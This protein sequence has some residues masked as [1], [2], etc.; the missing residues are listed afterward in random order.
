MNKKNNRILLIVLVA[1]LALYFGK[2]YLGNS[3]DRNFKS[4]LVAVDTAAVN[5]IV[6]N[7]KSNQNVPITLTRTGSEWE[8][9][10]GTIEDNASPSIMSGILSSLVSMKPERLIAK[11][12]DKW[13]T[14]QV[15]DSL[16]TDVKVYSDD[17]LLADLVVG[18]FNY[19]QATRSMS[20]S[21]RL[22]NS[23][24]VY[25]VKGYLSSTFN[26][27]TNDFRDK[28]FV[29]VKTEDLTKIAFTYPGDSSYV[30]EKSANGWQIDGQRADSV[31]VRNYLAGLRMM[32]MREFDDGFEPASHEHPYQ[33]MIDGDNINTITVT[34]YATE[35]GLVLH[36]SM[37]EDAY[38]KQ[39]SFKPFDKLFVHKQKFI[40]N[41]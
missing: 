13:D 17:K 18:K 36:S 30:L 1:L 20:T 26:R 16:G 5:K 29:K 7:A 38:F 37:N 4:E 12:K 32:N 25:T 10:D 33:V 14:N 28:S 27:K 34:G 39:A 6:V 8:V 40:G 23:E 11:S 41:N 2:K 31:N 9:S 22:A 21:V 19:N 35:N 3:G 15:S 24:D